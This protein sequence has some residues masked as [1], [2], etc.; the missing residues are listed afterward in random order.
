[1]TITLIGRF[2]LTGLLLCGIGVFCFVTL[3][4]R[5][6][7]AFMLA[8]GAVIAAALLVGIWAAP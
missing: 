7:R 3:S 2:V 1:M 8:G 6:A 4:D 5:A